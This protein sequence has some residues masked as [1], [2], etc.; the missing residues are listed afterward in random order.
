MFPSF[1]SSLPFSFIT[2]DSNID[3]ITLQQELS[4]LSSK[5]EEM[6]DKNEENE[7]KV[8]LMERE[9]RAFMMNNDDEKRRNLATIDELT[10]KVS[11]LESKLNNKRLGGGNSGSTGAGAGNGNFLFSSA[12]VD[13]GDGGSPQKDG[14][15]LIL[16]EIYIPV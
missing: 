9:N 2:T 11:E 12:S 1:L 14:K 13:A 8:K 7:R 10:L 5:Y 4:T 16:F 15:I 6:C 3:Y